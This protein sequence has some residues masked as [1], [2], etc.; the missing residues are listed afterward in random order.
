MYVIS[1]R[2]RYQSGKCMSC[3]RHEYQPGKCKSD[4]NLFLEYNSES[5]DA[6]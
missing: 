4:N 5:Q 1:L 6:H 2:H 3:L